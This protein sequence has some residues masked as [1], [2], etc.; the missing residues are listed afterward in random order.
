[1]IANT[2]LFFILLPYI[3]IAALPSDIQPFAVLFSIFY[4]FISRASFTKN[5][6][7]MIM[8]IV[9]SLILAIFNTAVLYE[10]S[11]V[12][13]FRYS[14]GYITPIVIYAY[15]KNVNFS[16]DQIR[17]TLDFV[18]VIIAIGYIINYLG[19][20][21]LI[22][23]FV[24]RAIYD[25]DGV[26]GFTS[27]FPEQSTV[28]SQLFFYAF[29]YYIFN[30]LN[31]YRLLII[32]FFALLSLSGQTFINLLAFFICISI[33]YLIIKLRIKSFL[34][35]AT[36]LFFINNI[37]L[38]SIGNAMNL[39]MRGLL[40]INDFYNQ[41]LQF[42]LVDKGIVYKLSGLIYGI[43]GIFDLNFIPSIYKTHYLDMLNTPYLEYICYELL[44]LNSLVVPHNPYSIFGSISYDFGLYGLLIL[45]FFFFYAIYIIN[46]GG[47]KSSHILI[48]F[49]MLF[50]FFVHSFIAQPTFWFIIFLI[51]A[52]REKIRV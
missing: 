42:L 41:G 17:K 13:I 16:R 23:P 26:R 20:T 35:I 36:F 49:F 33:Y 32:I 8:L 52:K 5:E 12:N 28:A 14:F 37:D 46:R 22:Q 50:L 4:L 21:Y 10:L 48:L 47:V 29:I 18:L 6:I 34:Y 30:S 40:V 1:M 39:P 38:I 2:V 3:G 44:N 9:F 7:M 43:A 51:L 19:L 24:N 25:A 31:R 27:F 45:I 11:Y 15:I